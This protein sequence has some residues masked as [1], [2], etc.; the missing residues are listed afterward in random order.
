MGVGS[1]VKRL[2]A[3]RLLS[4]GILNG[5]LKSKQ[6]FVAWQQLKRIGIQPIAIAAVYYLHICLLQLAETL[7]ASSFCTIEVAECHFAVSEVLET[8]EILIATVAA[9]K[10]AGLGIEMYGGFMLSLLIDNIF[11]YDAHQLPFFVGDKLWRRC[12]GGG[13]VRFAA[14]GC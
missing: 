11:A 12:D 2:E 3:E 1:I 8:A 9:A 5:L 13:F 7:G 10:G 14:E 6:H 4:G